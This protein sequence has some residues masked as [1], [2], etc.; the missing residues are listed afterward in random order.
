MTMNR[1]TR[2]KGLLILVILAMLSILV[3][4]FAEILGRTVY[5]WIH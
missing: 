1:I 3:L 4:F 5:Y 2:K